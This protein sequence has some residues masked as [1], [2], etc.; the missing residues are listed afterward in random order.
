MD[1][2]TQPSFLTNRVPDF[3]AGA[4]KAADATS[5]AMNRAATI[6]FKTFPNTSPDKSRADCWS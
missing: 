6:A 5:G 1:T 3:H 2:G 4:A